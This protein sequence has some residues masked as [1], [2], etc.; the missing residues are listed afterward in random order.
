M[1]TL[2]WANGRTVIVPRGG[3]DD[4]PVLGTTF[5]GR[6]EFLKHIRVGDEVEILPCTFNVFDDKAVEVHHNGNHIGHLPAKTGLAAY[7]YDGIVT[8]ELNVLRGIVTATLGGYEGK[9]YGVRVYLF[10]DDGTPLIF[11]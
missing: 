5:S 3:I 6:Q 7:V 4:V 9:N 11:P 10:D 2:Q 1:K 8:G